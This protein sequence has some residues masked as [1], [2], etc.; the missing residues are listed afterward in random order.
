MSA[1]TLRNATGLDGGTFDLTLA[2]GRLVPTA[3][4]PGALTVDLQGARVL[5]GLINAHDH[6]QLNALPRQPAGSGFR[7]ARDWTGV[8][9]ARRRTDR[10]FA[11]LASLN[12]DDRLL[13][14]AVKNL[15]SGVT[16]VAHHDPLYPLLSSRHFPLKVVQHYGW[17]HS[18]YLD[19]EPAVRNSHARTPPAS[20]WIIHAAE[21]VN[22]EA[23]AEFDR[24]EAL[25]CIGPN[26]LL[27]HGI[28][29]DAAQRQRLLDAGGG[30]IWCPSSN[31]HLF[32]RTAAVRSLAAAGRIALGSDSRLSGARDLLEELRLAATLG[33]V[34]E[35]ALE[36]MVGA[37]AAALLGLTHQ[38]LLAPG[39]PADLLILPPGARLGRVQRHEVRLVIVAGSVRYGDADLVLRVAPDERFSEVRVDGVRKLLAHAITA[40]LARSGLT[41]PGLELPDR[42]GRAA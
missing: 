7:H 26:T 38:G 42:A 20:P 13:F 23:A 22:A 29:L 4:P 25:G 8:V 41:E 11:A 39:C 15:L 28:A 36:R 1:C 18:L 10:H 24:L 21:G 37:D 40:Q 34:N 17:S 12:R 27:V 30:L 33:Q 19:G 5:P 6:L 16:T 32:A 14:G 35:A 9:A 3:L 2:G 31:L